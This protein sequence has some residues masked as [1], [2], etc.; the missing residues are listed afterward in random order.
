MRLPALSH[1]WFFTLAL[2]IAVVLLPSRP[3]TDADLGWHLRTGEW[4]V[5]NRDVMRV[6][7]FSHTYAGEPRVAFDWVSDIILYTVWQIGGYAALGLMTSAIFFVIFIVVFNIVPGHIVARLIVFPFFVLISSIVWAPRPHIISLLFTA[8]V[9]WLIHGQKRGGDSRWLWVLP[10]IFL[11][12]GNL[13]A[14]WALTALLMILT[15]IGEPL[16]RL[17]ANRTAH[18]MDVTRWRRFIGAGA[19]SAAA[20]VVNPFGI[21]AL[22]VPVIVLNDPSSQEFISEW[23]RTNLTSWRGAL[24]AVYLLLLVACV[25]VPIIRR[26][27]DW[28]HVLMMGVAV[29]IG[30]EYLRF[31]PFAVVIGAPIIIQE[32]SRWLNATEWGRRRA[33]P[34]PATSRLSFVFHYVVLGSLVALAVAYVAYAT[35]PNNI[36]EFQTN[37]WPLDAVEVMYEED[38]PR[39]LFNHYNWGGFLTWHAPDYPVFI[40]GRADLYTDFV[41]AA[42]DIWDGEGWEEAFAEWNINTV[43]VFPDNEIAAILRER[44]DWEIRHEDELSILLTRAR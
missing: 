19:A 43:L 14:G 29:Y 34:Q 38:L 40:D 15:A 7:H 11:L 31:V 22:I 27:G 2:F 3:P 44:D 35:N 5:E 24:L 23:Q 21:A 37:H 20:L 32:L 17:M 9:L 10:V 26:R 30:L 39:E 4:M 41:F 12:W 1:A 28:T 13:H 33:T 36:R 18:V 25:V 6:D 8:I 16:N 42:Q